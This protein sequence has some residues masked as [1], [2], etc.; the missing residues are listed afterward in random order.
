MVSGAAALVLP[1]FSD[2]AYIEIDEGYY[3]GEIDI[4][5]FNE[6]RMFTVKAIKD[7]ELLV[8]NQNVFSNHF[9]NCS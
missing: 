7:C 6:K 9:S 5:H 4:V 1:K 2:L 8:L 3:F